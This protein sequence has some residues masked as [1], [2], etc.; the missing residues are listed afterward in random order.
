MPQLFIFEHAPIRIH[1]TAGTR[2]GNH[3]QPHFP[4]AEVKSV[5][6][7]VNARTPAKMVGT[8]RLYQYVPYFRLFSGRTLETHDARARERQF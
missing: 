4:L 2:T 1:S 6:G 7:L 3:L 8:E 5:H